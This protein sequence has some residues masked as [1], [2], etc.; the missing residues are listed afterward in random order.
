MVSGLRNW[1]Q[2]SS[3]FRSGTWN[4]LPRMVI[5]TSFSYGRNGSDMCDLFFPCTSA[6]I[7]WARGSLKCTCLMSPLRVVRVT[8][9][10]NESSSRALLMC[11]GVET[12]QNSPERGQR[13]GG[14][15][16]LRLEEPSHVTK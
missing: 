8:V 2:R 13:D 16:G 5:S 1:K 7:C 3:E 9:E 10:D 15:E 11:Y 4:F 6:K 14:E 12:R